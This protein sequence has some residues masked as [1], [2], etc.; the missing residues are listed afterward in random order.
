M[1]RR[2]WFWLTAIAATIVCIWLVGYAVFSLG[3]ESPGSGEGDPITTVENG[4]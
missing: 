1:N 3:G 2:T 4:G